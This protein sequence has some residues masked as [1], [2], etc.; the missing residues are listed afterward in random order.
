M[1]S[2][3]GS[4]R[5]KIVV[6][7]DTQC[8]KTALLHVFAKD[9]YPENYVPTVFENYTAS[10][11]IDKQRIELNMWDTSGSAYYDNV[12]PLAYPD[13]DAVLICFDVSRPETLDSVTKKWQGETQEF[14][15]GAKVVLV[16]CKLD[17]R[18]DLSVMRELAK[19]RLI[20]VTHEQGTNLARQ[21]G[22]VAYAE[23][24]SRYSENSVRDVF[25]VTT[26]A[27]LSRIPHRPPLKR[28]GSRRGLKRV[29]QQ[30]PRTEIH[31]H[32]PTVRKDRAKSCVLM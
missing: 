13:A 14:C 21:I 7:G 29:S 31:E 9:S 17:M 11:E 2:N 22:A 4:L 27:S 16:G 12:R 19:H 8:G 20:P 26:L 32:P 30:P 25:H 1:E 15:P 10:F 24:T 3:K 18:T 6:V 5:C 23:C 28:A